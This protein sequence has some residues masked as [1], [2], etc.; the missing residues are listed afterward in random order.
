MTLP[1]ATNRFFFWSG[2]SNVLYEGLKT[3]VLYVRGTRRTSTT[4]SAHLYGLGHS[5]HIYAGVLD[6]DVGPVCPCP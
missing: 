4:Q 1:K 2:G 3:I 6:A 5:V